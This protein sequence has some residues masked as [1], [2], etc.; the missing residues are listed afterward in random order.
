MLVPWKK[1]YDQPI[2]HI[3]KERHHFVY[4]GPTSQ[5]CGFS[6]SNVRIWELDYKESRV[7]KNWCFRTVMLEK[8]LEIPWTARRSNQSI[9]KEISPEYSLEG[10]MLKLNTLATWC[11]E[12]AHWKRPWCWERLKAGGEGDNRG[13]DQKA[14]LTR[15]TWVWVNSGSWWWTGRPG[16]LQYMRS[17]R[18]GHNWATELNW[19]C[20]RQHRSKID[21][22]ET[23]AMCLVLKWFVYS[24]LYPDHNQLYQLKEE[25]VGPSLQ[26]CPRL[27]NTFF[28]S[29]STCPN[30]N[31]GRSLPSLALP[32]RSRS[33]DTESPY[34]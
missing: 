9:L 12:W 10:L 24:N 13:W 1:S 34:T 19:S 3:K 16:V 30:L 31:I 2:Q 18:V 29:H 7:P 11:E 28:P 4:K 15:W 22:L 33:Q 14:S 5:S 6:G 27:I 25:Q 8:T 21:D 20:G 17:R 23:G 32:P 26:P